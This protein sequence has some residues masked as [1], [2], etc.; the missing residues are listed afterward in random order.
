M[1]A[2]VQDAVVESVLA[3]SVQKPI[4]LLVDRLDQ[5]DDA[6]VAAL[7]EIAARAA[8][9]AVHVVAT[10]EPGGPAPRTAALLAFSRCSLDLPLGPLAQSEL[11][12]LVVELGELVVSIFS[13]VPYVPRLVERL[14]VAAHGNP[15]R[16]L[17]IL[18][19]LA[20]LG[21]VRHS[22]GRWVL[23]QDLP[24]GPFENASDQHLAQRLARMDESA[25]HIA[26]IL[27][28]AGDA[29]S[30]AACRAICRVPAPVLHAAV[31]SL[32][33]GEIIAA[34]HGAYRVRNEPL[35]AR[36]AAELEPQESAR[37]HRDLGR[38]RL[39]HEAA[40]L[41]ARID[42]VVHMLEG[43][44]NTMHAPPIAAWA[45]ELSRVS[46]ERLAELTPRL[47][48]A[49]Q[50][51]RDEGRSVCAQL[52]LINAL[53]YA[54]YFGDRRV[55][56]R[57]GPEAVRAGC[58]LIGLTLARSLAPLVGPAIALVVGLLVG[59]V[60]FRI[61]TSEPGTLPFRTAIVAVVASCSVMS[62]MSA[63]TIDP[64]NAARYARML[65]PL[66]G[67]GP[68]H[69][70]A[71]L[72]DFPAALAAAVTEHF[73][74]AERLLRSVLARVDGPRV[75]ALLSEDT[76]M[77]FSAGTLYALGVQAAWREDPDALAIA[78]RLEQSSSAFNGMSADQI[79]SL[80]YATLGDAERYEKLK[81][82]IEMH[83]IKRGTAWGVRAAP[84]PRDFPPAPSCAA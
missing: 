7:A 59:W 43:G 36:L 70:L 24:D 62:G 48:R 63:L 65:D 35:R 4:V 3:Y 33:A 14:Y 66:R 84:K 26:R 61:R 80:Y 16:S 30:L 40:D 51:F 73:D 28:V 68:S 29:V 64:A 79:R 41:A 31:E 12:E 38:Y 57:Y 42:A 22:E 58:E 69:P 67:F 56:E 78:D 19:A 6:S 18:R 75:R 54:G 2:E 39:E 1:R 74:D 13:D 53:T 25:R 15:L 60:R 72:A 10:I 77:R 17:E 23:P 52:G 82:K 21:A 44:V 49:L 32:V 27:S 8:Q 76:R 83:A 34:S 45:D 37:I 46:P 11:G 5:A 55:V 81:R 9:F 50:I 47:E 71:L 20:E